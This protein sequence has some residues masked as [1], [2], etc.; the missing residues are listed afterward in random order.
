MLRFVPQNELR[1]EQA[2][3]FTVTPGGAELNVAVGMARMGYRSAWV[4]RLPDNA[5][6]RLLL[7]R[8]REQNVDCSHVELSKDGRCGLYFLEHGASPRAAAVLYDL[9]ED[10]I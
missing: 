9:F 10:A 1:I 4:S 5:L 6:G 7:N 2:Q 8:A 3:A